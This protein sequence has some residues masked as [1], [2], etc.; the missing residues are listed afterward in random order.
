MKPFLLDTN[1]LIA[2]AWSN[3]VHHQEAITW[4]G[5]KAAKAFR[6][7]PITQT[8]FVRISSNPSFSKTAVTTVEALA[9]FDQIAALPGHAFW[10]DDLS[11]ADAMKPP[12]P[13]GSHRQISDAYLLAL[14]AAH[15]GVLATFDRGIAIISKAVPERLEIIAG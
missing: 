10:P 15:D 12:I 6:T 4:F 8:G 7:C 2:L 11:I 13:V 14:A 1:V 9:L 3:H 5:R